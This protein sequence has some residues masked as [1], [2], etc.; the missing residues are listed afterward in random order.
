MFV[1]HYSAAIA[2]KA[3]EPR[4]P[5]WALA[6][7]C[8]LIDIAWSVFIITGVEDAQV[9]HSLPG[10]PLVLSDMPWT[11]SL[12]AAL[13]WSIAA[14]L[15]AKPLLKLAWPVAIV[16]GATVFSHWL[17]DLLVHRP[18]LALW[19]G[20]PK[21]GFGLWDYEVPEQA[22]EIGLIAIAAVYWGASRR[23]AGAASTP[24]ALF[25]ALLLALQITAMFMPPEDIPLQMG[26]MSLAVYL[27]V[28]LAAVLADRRPGPG[29]GPG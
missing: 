2:A 15:A 27:V 11:H 12:P 14:A 22:V 5:F 29:R 9:D 16:I 1:G 21:I 20:G 7:A 25:I 4:A 24:P 19:P 3:A 13:I 17:L 10:S 18:D 23:A 26:G 8:Q 6:G 28:V